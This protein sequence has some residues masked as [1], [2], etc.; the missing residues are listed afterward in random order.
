VRRD[1]VARCREAFHHFTFKVRLRTLVFLFEC[2]H[3][4]CRVFG[5]LN[6]LP[7]QVIGFQV[8]VRTEIPRHMS[9]AQSVA[10]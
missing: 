9:H 4:A 5:M 2:A 3:E 7:A 1:T 8:V 10:R 6:Q